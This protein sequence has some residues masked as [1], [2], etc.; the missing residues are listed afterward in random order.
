MD[1]RIS[2]YKFNINKQI[3][4][5]IPF[6]FLKPL[7]VLLHNSLFLSVDTNYFSLWLNPLI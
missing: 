5:F 3:F 7:N 6:S 4:V 2:E 1:V